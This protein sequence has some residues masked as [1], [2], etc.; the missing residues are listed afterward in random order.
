MIAFLEGTIQSVGS[1]ALV[2]RVGGIGYQ[3]FYTDVVPLAGDVLSVHI[4]DYIR[5]DRHE[6]YGFVDEGM[7]DL[8]ARMIDISG[9]G[10]RMAQKILRAAPR[11]RLYAHIQQG[12]V[13]FLTQVQGV[14]KKTAQKIIL[15]LQ[16]VLVSLDAVSTEDV[17][18]VDALM[19]LGYARGDAQR[20][21]SQLSATTTE[22]RIREALKLLG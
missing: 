6:L 11:E 19:S 10:P 18:T 22:D 7:R 8:F 12:D 14:G 9:I 13:A 20:V 4:F 5:E 1:D 15:E 17:D 3:V 21:A 16:G 2:L